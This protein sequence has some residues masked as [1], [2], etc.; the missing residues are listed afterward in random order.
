MYRR[1][2]EANN[3]WYIARLFIKLHEIVVE[4]LL[5]INTN[6]TN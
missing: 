2:V 1:V 4:I 5:L 6:I 3:K